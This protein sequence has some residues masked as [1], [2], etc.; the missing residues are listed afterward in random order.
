MRYYVLL[1][2]T[3]ICYDRFVFQYMIPYLTIYTYLWI[4]R[5]ISLSIH[6][7]IVDGNYHL[8]VNRNYQEL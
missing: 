2:I 6:L 8:F 7:S 1:Y 4:Y 5:F 3:T